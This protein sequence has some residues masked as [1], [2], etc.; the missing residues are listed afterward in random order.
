[1][2]SLVIQLGNS[3]GNL[4]AEKS[5]VLEINKKFVFETEILTGGVETIEKIF[6]EW[7]A[8]CEEGAS[9]EPFFRPE[10]FV[11]FVKNFEKEILLITV[12][13]NKKLRAV[14]PLVRKNS[15]LH[16]VPARKLQAVFNLQT[17][18]FDLIHGSDETERAE[19]VKAVWQE[20][21]RQ[22]EWDVLEM[23]LIKK[24]SWLNDLLACAAGENHPTGIW[25]MDA[26]PFITLPQ[27]EDKE[28]LIE[29]FFKGSR[30]HLRQELNR[31]LRRLKELGKVEFVVTREYSPELMQR[32]F[33]LE[34]EGWKGRGGTA[35]TCDPNVAQMHNDFARA[36]A[37]ANALFIYELKLD[38]KTIAMSV[39]IIYDKQTI[40]WKTSYDEKYAR[41]S[42]G[43]LLF[44]ELL[45]DCVRRDS[46]EIDFLSPAT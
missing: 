36:V 44:R 22:S 27:G 30:K 20:I 21:K 29:E 45:S 6:S 32:Y 26:A 5:T 33:E 38:D 40:H 31:R 11:A 16:G 42:P 24:D 1:M 17:Q 18:R 35:V 28:T 2:S 9:N 10:W 23:R 3:D 14:L 4:T 34:A 13:R 41:Y 25:Q 7:T 39:N 37:A 43:N 15:N 19:I 12:R 46:P 8:L